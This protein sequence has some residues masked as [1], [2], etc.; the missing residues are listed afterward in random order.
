MFENAVIERFAF[1]RSIWG[2]KSR[3]KDRVPH[4]S[5]KLKFAD[6]EGKVSI[7]Q[8]GELTGPIVMTNLDTNGIKE[9]RVIGFGEKGKKQAEI[10]R[11]QISA[12]HPNVAWEE[13]HHAETPLIQ[14]VIET[15]EVDDIILRRL[16]AK[17]AFESWAEKRASLVAS[18]SQYAQIRDFILTGNHDFCSGVLPAP[19]PL[20]GLSDLPVGIHA[21]GIVHNVSSPILGAFIVFFGLFHYWVLISTS[22]QSLQSDDE[23]W[24]ENPQKGYFPDSK[25]RCQARPILIDWGQYVRAWRN[26]PQGILKK[27]VTYNEAKFQEA[28]R[29]ALQDG[30]VLK[31]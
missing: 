26:D 27:A 5:T 23:F 22:Y 6:I 4:V 28:W 3:K 24:I 10:K 29:E 13:V 31:P 20:T 9:Y 2:I 19:P 15:P 25:L 17:V 1:F 7:D 12:K 18:D 30:R 11:Q 14:F 16:A 21:G 8:N